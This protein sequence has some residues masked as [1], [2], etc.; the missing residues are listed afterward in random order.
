MFIL[1]TDS[2]GARSVGLRR[3]EDILLFERLGHS[4]TLS[5]ACTSPDWEGFFC[6]TRCNFARNPD[7]PK[8]RGEILQKRDWLPRW[9]FVFP[10]KETAADL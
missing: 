6:F 10:C 3:Q 7:W 1:R 9:K 5:S 4:G 2:I 8:D